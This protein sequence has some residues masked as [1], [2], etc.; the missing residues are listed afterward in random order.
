VRGLARANFYAHDYAEA[1]KY[2][3]RVCDY[4]TKE[5]LT[6]DLQKAQA[7]LIDCYVQEQKFPQAEAS[8][9]NLLAS[10][11]STKPHAVDMAK[12]LYQLAWV[13]HKQHK[14]VEAEPYYKR[15]IAIYTELNDKSSNAQHCQDDYQRLLKA[16]TYEKDFPGKGD[17]E[18]WYAAC[19]I[20]SDGLKLYRAGKNE[21]ALAMYQKAIDGY[22]YDYRFFYSLGNA[23]HVLQ[24]LELATEAYRKSTQMN[25]TYFGS[26]YNL[27]LNLFEQGK[28][29][30][31]KEAFTQAVVLPKTETEA[32]NMQWYCKKLNIT[33]KP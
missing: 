1:E 7:L 11:Q 26:Q 30:E 10:L 25:A 21:E 2:Y 29:D 5:K 13:Y 14:T 6:D 32:K 17:K 18:A 28:L 31:A 24:K 3:A 15:A 27:G 20:W 4:L 16:Q 8:S 19:H 22:P 33:V 9:L 23:Y 12:S